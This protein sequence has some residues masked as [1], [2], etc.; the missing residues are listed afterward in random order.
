MIAYALFYGII[1]YLAFQ[2][3][4]PYFGLIVVLGLAVVLGIFWL[5]LSLV[6]YFAGYM[7]AKMLAAKEE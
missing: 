6:E 2:F 3:Q 4:K 1:G 7:I 5:P